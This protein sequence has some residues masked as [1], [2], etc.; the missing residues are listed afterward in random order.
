MHMGQD[1]NLLGDE[2]ALWRRAR[3]RWR[4][5]GA[6]APGASEAPEA[7]NLAAYLDDRLAPRDRERIEAWM[8][9][10][11]AALD[12]II[13]ARQALSAGQDDL[14]APPRLV[15]RAQALVPDRDRARRGRALPSVPSGRF[16]GTLPLLWRGTAWAGVA[17]ATL[18]LCVTGFEL[19][20]L[21]TRHLVALEAMVTEDLSFGLGGA[22]DELL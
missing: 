11:D 12:L 1:I 5:P 22:A 21:G 15:T 6:P 17:L 7:L 20:R 18:L 4:A 19:G 14:A 9:G 16:F 3:R 8:L 10:E 13:A 2:A